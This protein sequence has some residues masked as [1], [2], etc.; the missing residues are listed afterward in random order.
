MENIEGFVE[1]NG[2]C[3]LFL[4]EGVNH[5]LLIDS[6]ANKLAMIPTDLVHYAINTNLDPSNPVSRMNTNIINIEGT[7]FTAL[8]FDLNEK[9]RILTIYKD[10]DKEYLRFQYTSYFRNNRD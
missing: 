2:G 9:E 6:K 7:S 5:E 4:F 1:S 10:I 8:S 3:D